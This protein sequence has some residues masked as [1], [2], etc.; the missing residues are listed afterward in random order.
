M[1][2][3]LIAFILAFI[4]NSQFFA[5]KIGLPIPF[6][7]EEKIIKIRELP[8][9]FEF[10]IR[11]GSNYDIGSLYTVKRFLWLGYSYGEPKFVGYLNSQKKYAPFTSKELEQI[12]VR[13]NIQLPEKAEI[14]FFD[15]Y[16]S[17]LLLF[18]ILSLSSLYGYKFYVRRRKVLTEREQEELPSWPPNTSH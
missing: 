7:T 11:D 9:N 4:F 10:R 16:I 1:K 8:D 13:A 2:I 12:A 6:G 5:S 15:L 18:V 3:S 14:S 17:R